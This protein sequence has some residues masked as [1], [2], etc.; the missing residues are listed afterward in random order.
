MR[1]LRGALHASGRRLVSRGLRSR[2][3]RG[4]NADYQR[5]R[6]PPLDCDELRARAQRLGKSLGRFQGLRIDEHA[7]NLFWVSPGMSA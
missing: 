7:A 6:F 1:R 3:S 2:L 5:H 4:K